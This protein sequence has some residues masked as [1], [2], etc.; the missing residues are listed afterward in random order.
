[1]FIID[2]KDFK[3]E[4]YIVGV[5]AF[6]KIGEGTLAFADLE[7]NSNIKEENQGT[8]IYK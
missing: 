6:S 5:A 1:M 3:G 2:V 4:Y 7:I 8:Y